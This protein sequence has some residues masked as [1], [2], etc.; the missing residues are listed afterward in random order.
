ML[1]HDHCVTKYKFN[2]NTN[3]NQ[4]ADE[5]ILC[6]DFNTACN[7]ISRF[8]PSIGN[9]WKEQSGYARRTYCVGNQKSQPKE[10]MVVRL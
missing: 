10:T 8:V 5:L 9:D 6:G 1:N 4:D 7:G 2:N 3:C